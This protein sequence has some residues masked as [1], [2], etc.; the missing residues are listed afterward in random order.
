MENNNPEVVKILVVNTGST[1]ISFEKYE[2]QS[3]ESKT[4]QEKI[5]ERINALG[6]NSHALLKYK[7][8]FWVADHTARKGPSKE[9]YKHKVDYHT[10]MTELS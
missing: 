6:K 9:Y 8:Q 1:P 4:I 10:F 5:L 7:N 2:F 3:S